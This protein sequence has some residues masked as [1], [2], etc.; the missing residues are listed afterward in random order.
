MV[1]KEEIKRG[2]WTQKEF[3]VDHPL[4][5]TEFI[6]D[7]TVKTGGL[8]TS[9]TGFHCDVSVLD[10]VVVQENAYTEDGRKKDS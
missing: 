2:L 1:N 8:T 6:R 7:P 9:L 10:D 4:R 5:K 3:S